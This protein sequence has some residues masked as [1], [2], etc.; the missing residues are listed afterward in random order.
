MTDLMELKDIVPYVEGACSFVRN[1]ENEKTA[2]VIRMDEWRIIR[3]AIDRALPKEPKL[4]RRGKCMCGEVEKENRLGHAD[5]CRYFSDS[6][7]E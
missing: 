6:V 1:A 3:A 4:V 5:G 2:Y 7:Y